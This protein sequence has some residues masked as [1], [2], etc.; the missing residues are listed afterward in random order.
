MV[1]LTNLINSFFLPCSTSQLAARTRAV[2]KLSGGNSISPISDTFAQRYDTSTS[3]TLHDLFQGFCEKQKQTLHHFFCHVFMG[4]GHGSKSSSL[5]EAGLFTSTHSFTV[6][7]GH[8]VEPEEEGILWKIGDSPPLVPTHVMLGLRH[9]L[10]KRKAKQKGQ[11][12][13]GKKAFISTAIYLCKA[14]AKSSGCSPHYISLN[15]TL[16]NYLPLSQ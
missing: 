12:K 5:F 6:S 10:W 11:K 4:L 16:C 14:P 3:M 7:T 15:N 8:F 9:S 2:Q 13:G 1:E